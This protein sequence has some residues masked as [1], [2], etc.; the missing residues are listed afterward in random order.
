MEE[1]KRQNPTQKKKKN[2]KQKRA[3]ESTSGTYRQG[4]KHH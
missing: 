4:R 1:Y 2:R 3:R